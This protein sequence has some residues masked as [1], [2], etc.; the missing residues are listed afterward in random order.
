MGN[1][2]KEHLEYTIRVWQKYFP[3]P[4]TIEKAQEI[5]DNVNG[6]YR[7]FIEAKIDRLNKQ[8]S[9]NPGEKK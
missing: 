3:Y 6:F 7:P 8:K 2:S 5:C 1:Y 9:K 4:I